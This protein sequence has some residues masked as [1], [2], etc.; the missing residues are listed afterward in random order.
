MS[1]YCD[2]DCV[3]F[4][5]IWQT[6]YPTRHHESCST[7]LIRNEFSYSNISILVS[8]QECILHKVLFRCQHDTCSC[9]LMPQDERCVWLDGIC[10]SC[11]PLVSKS[12]H[13]WFR[14]RYLGA[15][16]E[17]FTNHEQSIPSRIQ[18]E[19]RRSQY[20]ILLVKKHV[21]NSHVNFVA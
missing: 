17:R 10:N 18:Q 7:Q 20:P 21:S 19:R 14:W 11:S 1:F 2:K 16:E 8:T 5:R 13:P 3:F 6:G 12:W 4:V 15:L 9:H